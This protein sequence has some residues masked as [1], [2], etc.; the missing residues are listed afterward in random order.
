MIHT[1]QIH[2]RLDIILALRP[3]HARFASIYS[4]SPRRPK[5]TVWKALP[6][7]RCVQRRNENFLAARSSPP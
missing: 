7:R 1:T 3:V 5:R 4:D 2:L 6:A